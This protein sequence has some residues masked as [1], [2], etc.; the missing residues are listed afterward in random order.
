MT[1]AMRR[2]AAFD[3]SGQLAKKTGM[4]RDWN[5]QCQEESEQAKHSMM[6]LKTVITFKTAEPVKLKISSKVWYLRLQNY[7]IH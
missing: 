7:K 6:A 1:E 3:C 5:S 2:M 4:L